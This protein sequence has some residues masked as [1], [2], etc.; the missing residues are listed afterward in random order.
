MDDWGFHD[1]RDEIMAL[2][3]DTAALRHVLDCFDQVDMDPA[4]DTYM[5]AHDGDRP[6]ILQ[7]LHIDGV[8]APLALFGVARGIQYSAKK[9]GKM[10]RYSHTCGERT[11]TFPYLYHMNQ[12][13]A[14][15][16]NPNGLFDQDG[17]WLDD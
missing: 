12:T 6:P 14:V 10:T 11:R 16:H 15:L 8:R 13:T 5:Q 7:H 9:E 4:V 1:D 3:C 17:K 2:P